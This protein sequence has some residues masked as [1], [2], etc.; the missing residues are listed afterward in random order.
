MFAQFFINGLTTGAL[1]S[2]TALGFAL[3]YNTTGIFHIAAAAVY[4]AAE[5]L[6]ANAR[7]KYGV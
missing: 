5:N 1:Y 7:K 2:L 6:H 4:T 3:V